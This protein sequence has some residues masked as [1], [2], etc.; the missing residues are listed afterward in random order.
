[1]EINKDLNQ[2]KFYDAL[3]KD[4]DFLNKHKILCRTFVCFLLCKMG[5]HNNQD[6]LKGIRIACID[7]STVLAVHH[8][9]CRYSSDEIT[10]TMHID[11]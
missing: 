2:E 5:L 7:A 1:M 11:A 8:D 3:L 10:T 9:I 4:L 6:V